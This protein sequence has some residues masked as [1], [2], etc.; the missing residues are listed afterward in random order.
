M[1]D[2]SLCALQPLHLMQGNYHT[3]MR[4]A[5]TQG[6]PPSA[7]L[8]IIHEMRS[9]EVEPTSHSYGWVVMAFEREEDY[10]GARAFVDAL[11]ADGESPASSVHIEDRS[12][13][14]GRLSPGRHVSNLC[15]GRFWTRLCSATILAT[16]TSSWCYVTRCSSAVEHC[17]CRQDVSRA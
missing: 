15:G 3:I 13:L 17:H 1:P 9:H 8:D 7:L 2:Q 4:M 6:L 12:W 10:E 5:Y 16:T 14:A 11:R